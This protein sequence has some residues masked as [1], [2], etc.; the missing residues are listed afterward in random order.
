MQTNWHKSIAFWKVPRLRPFVLLVRVTCGWRWVWSTV[1]MILTRENWSNWRKTCPIA[2]LSIQSWHGEAWDRK[3]GFAEKDRRLTSFKNNLYTLNYL[4]NEEFNDLYYSS[5][6]VRV[7]KSR[8]IR[9]AGHVQRMGRGKAYTGY[10][11]RNLRKR[12]HLE[13]PGV[14][15]RII[16]LQQNS[17][18][19]A[20]VYFRVARWD[21]ALLQWR[22]CSTIKYKT[23]T[24]RWYSYRTVP[25]LIDTV[26]CTEYATY[27]RFF[28][29]NI[30]WPIKKFISYKLW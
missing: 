23:K 29:C 28:Q 15:G 17:C 20:H 18:F 13:D 2:T 14:E 10:R 12:G 6:I 5:N 3:S 4:H 8:R 19:F 27:F 21:I 1:G 11:W 7:I 30:C 16:L 24:I 9:K 22:L 25:F 26:I